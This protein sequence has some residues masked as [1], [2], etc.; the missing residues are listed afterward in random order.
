[1]TVELDRARNATCRGVLRYC[2]ILAS[3][4][5]YNESLQLNHFDLLLA[6]FPAGLVIYWA[7]NNTLSVFQQSAIMH[8]HGAKIQLWDNLKRMFIQKKSKP[9]PWGADR[10]MDGHREMSASN[11]MGSRVVDG[12]RDSNSDQ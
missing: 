2:G 1:L 4:G 10:H 3:Y 6:K 7:W 9:T 12:T 5:G 8:R 11:G